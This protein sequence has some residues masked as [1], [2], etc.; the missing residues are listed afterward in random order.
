MIRKAN[1]SDIPILANHHER[2]FREIYQFEKKK[3]IEN[4]FKKMAGSY[5]TKLHK[6]FRDNSCIAWIYEYNHRIVASAAISKI[7]VVSTPYDENVI[8]GYLHGVFTEPEYRK[9]GYAEKLIR[10]ILVYCQKNRIRRI[11]LLASKAGK[12]IYQKIGFAKLN[13]SMRYI[14]K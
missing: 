9:N 11:D 7:N 4:A 6:Q 14:G 8:T 1:I 5:K 12:E 3:I 2:M 13:N 10:K